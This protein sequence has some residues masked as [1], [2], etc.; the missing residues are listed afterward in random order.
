MTMGSSIDDL[1]ELFLVVQGN[2]DFKL[3]PAQWFH[4]L[5]QKN[6][7]APESRFKGMKVPFIYVEYRLNEL[8]ELNDLHQKIRQRVAVLSRLVASW[9]VF[10]DKGYLNVTEETG[11]PPWKADQPFDYAWAAPQQDIVYNLR[12]LPTPAQLLEVEYRLRLRNRPEKSR[13]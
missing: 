5:G 4:N 12:W 7:S 1:H 2:S 8:C 10:D 13:M 9:L 6:T 3:M 11:L